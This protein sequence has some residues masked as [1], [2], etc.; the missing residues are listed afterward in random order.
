MA[1]APGA[2]LATALAADVTSVL[3]AL[4]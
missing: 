4:S 2:T 1:L 3:A